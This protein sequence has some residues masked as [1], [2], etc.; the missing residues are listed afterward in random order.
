MPFHAH[1]LAHTPNQVIAFVKA[2]VDL[3]L[4]FIDGAIDYLIDLL[5]SLLIDG[6]PEL[7]ALFTPFDFD[8]PWNPLIELHFTGKCLRRPWC[9]GVSVS[10]SF[11]LPSPLHTFFPTTTVN[12]SIVGMFEKLS[13]TFSID[14]LSP[15][16]DIA[17]FMASIIAP[18]TPLVSREV[19]DRV[20]QLNFTCDPDRIPIVMTL[21]YTADN[22][23]LD[24]A[25]SFRFPCTGLTNTCTRQDLEQVRMNE[26][27]CRGGECIF[28]S[29]LFFHA[30]RQAIP[31]IH[32]PTHPPVL[33]ECRYCKMAGVVNELTH[34]PTHPP[35]HRLQH[36][37]ES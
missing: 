16:K 27:W 32:P 3:L 23:N 1:A 17:T 28:S 10:F 25:S 13:D 29:L 26:G 33:F 20:P 8:T 18:S 21:D 30:K 15:Q 22:C 35:T 37:I 31:S 6:I 12:T 9:Q 34:L 11:L 2:T 19:Y 14:R 24:L 5:V 4:G 36:L 7:K